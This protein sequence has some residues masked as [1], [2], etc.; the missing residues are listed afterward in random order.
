LIV[1]ICDDSLGAED[2]FAASLRP[3]VQ[4]QDSDILSQLGRIIITR[5]GRDHKLG[6]Q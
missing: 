5:G 2:R 4:A 1:F 6:R 3:S